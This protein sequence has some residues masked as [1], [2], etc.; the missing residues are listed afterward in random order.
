MSNE[1]VVKEG[2]DALNEIEKIAS[3]PAPEDLKGICEKYKKIKPF[4]EKALI[5]VAMI[6]VYGSKIAAAIRFL[7]G[8]ADTACTI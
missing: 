6:P 1:A 2:L 3:E 5:F 7:M 4:L 8:V